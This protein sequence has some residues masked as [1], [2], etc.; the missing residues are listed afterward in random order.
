[1]VIIVAITAISSYIIPNYELANSVRIIRF[2]LM[3]MASIFGMVGIAIGVLIVLVHLISVRSVGMDYGDPLIPINFRD[4][5]D[6][7]IR[8]PIQFMRKRPSVNHPLQSRR[9]GQGKKKRGY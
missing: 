5:K 1:M 7:L 8:A 4:W 3:L 2:P 9:Q 6:T